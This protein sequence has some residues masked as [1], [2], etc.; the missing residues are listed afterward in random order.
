MN[1]TRSWPPHTLPTCFA[2]TLCKHK[3]NIFN[4]PNSLITFKSL[5]NNLPKAINLIPIAERNR[6]DHSYL[7]TAK[8]PLPQW[9]MELIELAKSL[10]ESNNFQ[11]SVLKFGKLIRLI[12]KFINKITTVGSKVI[13][14]VVELEPHV[15]AHLLKELGMNGSNVVGDIKLT[16]SKFEGSNG[17]EYLIQ[18][19]RQYSS[20]GPVARL[21]MWSVFVLCLVTY[22]H[23]H[24]GHICHKYYMY[25]CPNVQISA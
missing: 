4:R 2:Q 11:G 14:P 17:I 23:A 25:S 8:L 24:C 16:L 9:F 18:K 15:Q 12:T 21:L 5:L 22:G 3:S 10:S 19:T 13:W 7:V 1:L 6:S 20:N